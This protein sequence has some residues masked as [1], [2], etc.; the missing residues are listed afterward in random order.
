MAVRA[1]QWH[2]DNAA[3]VRILQC[4]SSKPHLQLLALRVADSC[5]HGRISLFPVWIPRGDNFVADDLSRNFEEDCDD[6]QLQSRWFRYLDGVWGPHTVD[7]FA[8]NV[9]THLPV[10]YSKRKL[11]RYFWNRCIHSVLGGSE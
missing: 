2:C 6:W 8:N 10:F 7:L 3:A 4:G 9:N 5:L 1:L 11:S